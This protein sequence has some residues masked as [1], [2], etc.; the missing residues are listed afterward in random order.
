MADRFFDTSAIAKHYRMELGTAQVD[1]FL[2][3]KA[4]RHFVSVLG[5]TELHP[6]FV[7]LVR[8]NQI[9]AADFPVVRGRFFSDLAS[10]L[11]QVVPMSASH[12]HDA[13]QI[14]IRHGLTRSLYTSDALQLA[15]ALAQHTATPLDAFVRADRDD[16]DKKPF[17]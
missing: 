9:T 6:V 1:S 14:L 13:Q 10:G 11:W 8:T 17:T 15:A 2:A 7:R 5:A 3:E 4:S 16:R 12:F